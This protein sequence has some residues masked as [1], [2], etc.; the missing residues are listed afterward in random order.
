[1]YRAEMVARAVGGV[2]ST[3]VADTFGFRELKWDIGAGRWSL[4]VKGGPMFVRGACYAPSYRLDELTPERFDA[5]LRI[6]KE[7][8][9]DALRIV[10]NVLPAEFYRRADAAGM[11]LV[12]ELPLYGAYAYHA[13]GD[14]SRFFES[15]ARE[16]QVEMV[17]LLRNRPSVA[18]WV[19]HDDPPSLPGD[20]SPRAVNSV[21]PKH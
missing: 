10:A 4:A 19:A 11:L 16:Q 2:E 21:R 20:S 13:R 18:M 14:D 12:Q 8:N 9:L 15:A 1:M 6:A 17:E 3:R 7:T 5:D